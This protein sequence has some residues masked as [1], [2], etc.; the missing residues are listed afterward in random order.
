[1]AVYIAF[2]ELLAV[3]LSTEVWGSEWTGTHVLCYCDNE[4]AT[5]MVAS[6]SSKNPDLMHLLRCLFFIEAQFSFTLTLKHIPGVENDRADDL[7]R[8]NLSSILSKVLDA[9]KIPTPLPQPL[10][11]LLLDTTAIW[12][13]PCWTRRFTSI[14]NSA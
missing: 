13:S 11:E 6:R 4:A 1:M 5:H 9:Q 8:N 12:T 10:L 14:V 3:V 7:S 2:K